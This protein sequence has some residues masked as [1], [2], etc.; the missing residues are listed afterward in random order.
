M[1]NNLDVEVPVYF[2][3]IY[4]NTTS[5]QK[6]KFP[7][8]TPPPNKIQDTRTVFQI[9]QDMLGIL[10]DTPKVNYKFYIDML[11]KR[12]S[13]VPEINSDGIE[14]STEL[15][16]KAIKDFAPQLKEM[17]SNYLK[18]IQDNVIVQ[19]V[20][21]NI[22]PPGS[23]PPGP[24]LFLKSTI[25]SSKCPQHQ[26]ALLT[27]CGATNSCISLSNLSTLGIDV[28]QISTEVKY[29]LTNVTE[30]NN[31]TTILGSIVLNTNIQIKSGQATIAIQYLVLDAPL[32]YTILGSLE[33]E[34]CKAILCIPCKSLDMIL[35]QENKLTW[36]KPTVYISP[37]LEDPSKNNCT[38]TNSKSLMKSLKTRS[39]TDVLK[40][41]INNMEID[42]NS[43]P[44]S[45]GPQHDLPGLHSEPVSEKFLED[46]D[47][48]IQVPS[49]VD[50]NKLDFDLDQDFNH[51]NSD[52]R[53][54]L[55][56][57]SS[58]HP[59]NKNDV[60]HFP[61]YRAVLTPAPDANFVAE[62]PRRHEPWKQEI[63]LE[64][65]AD[66]LNV[67]V[68]EKSESMY[69]CNALLT[70]KAIPF[71]VGSNTKADRH[72]QKTSQSPH[73]DISQ[74][75]FRYTVDQRSHN[76]NLLPAPKIHLPKTSDILRILHGS[77]V[78]LF[79]ISNAFHSV[80][81]SPSSR[82]YTSFW[83]VTGIKYQF[84][85]CCQGMQASPYHFSTPV[86]SI[87]TAVAFKEFCEEYNYTFDSVKDLPSEWIIL[88]V[89]D[90][91]IVVLKH[92]LVKRLHFVLHTLLKHKLKINFSKLK[93]GT[94]SFS[95]LGSEYNLKE[96]VSSIKSDRRNA[97]LAYREPR[98]F[99]EILSR[100]AS[101]NYNSRFL[102]GLQKFLVPL[103]HLLSL[104]RQGVQFH[105]NREHAESWS[106][107]KMLL[108]LDTKLYIPDRTCP[109]LILP[110]ANKIGFC[111]SLYA[112][113]TEE[114]QIGKR[115]T[116]RL[117]NLIDKIFS[118]SQL[119]HH[120]T[121]KE[122]A[123]S[124]VSVK[125]F[126]IP[127]R[128]SIWSIL[129]SD[130]RSLSFARRMKDT[131]S[132]LFQDASF[133]SS[134]SNLSHG[135]IPG[136]YV[137]ISDAVTR[138]FENSQILEDFPVK[139]LKQMP[140][141]KYDKPTIFT[142]EQV[143]QVIWTDLHKGD[144]VD[145]T[146]R[147]TVL[148]NPPI[149]PQT[150]LMQLLQASPQEEF[151]N[152]LL[153]G[154]ISKN[155]TNWT[156]IN[157]K[158]FT[159][160]DF[161]Q[162]LTKCEAPRVLAEINRILK[163]DDL[164]RKTQHFVTNMCLKV[165]VD[166]L[167]HA[168]ITHDPALSLLLD[169]GTA[170]NVDYGPRPANYAACQ[171]YNSGSTQPALTDY[172][173]QYPQMATIDN[174]A[175]DIIHQ[176]EIPTNH[177]FLLGSFSTQELM[178]VSSLLQTHSN[179]FP[180]HL[181]SA[182]QSN[183]FNAII[184]FLLSEISESHREL[185]L[186]YYLPPSSQ[187]R[188]QVNSHPLRIQLISTQEISI[189]GLKHI[190]LPLNLQVLNRS[191]H[192]V[193]SASHKKPD[194]YFSPLYS[195]SVT[196]RHEF[197]TIL[198]FNCTPTAIRI[199][200]DFVFYSL[201]G[202]LNFP[203]ENGH[204]LQ[205]RN[206]ENV[207]C[208]PSHSPLFKVQ[209]A[210]I[211][212]DKEH[213]FVL[214]CHNFMA[215]T[216]QLFH[217]EEATNSKN[218]DP[219][220]RCRYQSLFPVY[221][222]K[223]SLS[224]ETSQNT[225]FNYNDMKINPTKQSF[226]PNGS[227]TLCKSKTCLDFH[228]YPVLIID[229]TIQPIHW[230]NHTKINLDF[231]QDGQDM[232]VDL[233]KQRNK[234]KH[235]APIA[236]PDMFPYQDLGKA[237][238]VWPERD[239]PLPDPP[240][241]DQQQNIDQIFGD[242]QTLQPIPATTKSSIPFVSKDHFN[243][244]LFLSRLLKT[245]DRLTPKDISSLQQVEPYFREIMSTIK[246]EKNF[247][248][249]KNGILFKKITKPTGPTFYVLCLP[250]QFAISILQSFH[251]IA[252]FHVPKN[253][254]LQHYNSRFFTPNIDHLLQQSINSCLKCFLTSNVGVRN[255]KMFKR[256]ITQCSVGEHL[257]LDLIT[258]LPLSNEGFTTLLLIVDV[259]SHYMIGLPLANMQGPAINDA[260]NTIFNI[261]PHPKYLSC[262]HQSSFHTIADFCTRYDI[263]CIKS[264]PS[265]KNELGAID[266]ACRIVTQFLQKVTTSI[267]QTLRLSWPRYIKILFENINAR[268]S[269]RNKFSRTE[270]FYGPL[271]YLPN[272]RVFGS[273]VFDLANDMLSEVKLAQERKLIASEKRSQYT[274][275][276]SISFPRN[277]LVK[278]HLSKSDK[279]TVAGSKKLIPDIQSFFR[280][281]R[282]GPT[283]CQLKNITDGTVRTVKKS[284]L[285]LVTFSENQECLKLIRE[286]FPK[287]LLW[288]FN[289]F[290]RK[291]SLPAY[292]HHMNSKVKHVTFNKQVEVLCLETL[293]KLEC[294]FIERYQRFDLFPQFLQLNKIFPTSYIA[295]KTED[296]DFKN[297]SVYH[298]LFSCPCTSPKEITM[299][300]ND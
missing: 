164:S 151:L 6:F 242:L 294:D 36:S 198:L 231:V 268:Y 85:R 108:Y 293:I 43:T 246:K 106:H 179:L 217:P 16:R 82:Q 72:I 60:G 169:S 189:D 132:A 118:G 299:L 202:W 91:L 111:G 113:L 160:L 69:P 278:F 234:R 12:D 255:F 150:C 107:C 21:L 68:I 261:I 5:I 122:W 46:M 181:Q 286:N 88:Y 180:Q 94:Y 9:F 80:E 227:D 208:L 128:A 143:N 281:L 135:F 131:S 243:S 53:A 221:P 2:Q 156:Q 116:L 152:L 194:M 296:R 203:N 13:S 23:V 102:P 195:T 258:N 285:T 42:F 166:Q 220:M 124:T 248:L 127:I 40:H 76:N 275:L 199:P 65:E 34:N 77:A 90:L 229:N 183:N 71:E 239:L 147:K 17:K 269:N 291:Q 56:S 149:N 96:S 95:F 121:R 105:W 282:S 168:P 204:I 171:L 241:E 210:Q 209:E 295:T 191:T 145:C 252:N 170:L 240:T 48:K 200:P 98:S 87:F 139:S 272:H 75:K 155:H 54:L 100:I 216:F 236:K 289:S 205:I 222:F 63:G 49:S 244:L 35:W 218:Y 141:I 33:L 130:C 161:S 159:Q 187:F 288:E 126:E 66:L 259:A 137:G 119:N 212:E 39:P 86:S 260:L 123:A 215:S 173:N 283:S 196:A 298:L 262:D 228:E 174:C 230:C 74:R 51:L 266:S 64:I 52:I 224:Q 280:V 284:A 59:K 297:I 62:P 79:D 7:L 55:T 211:Y 270:Q 247:E 58:L 144:M 300:I 162:L 114:T 214:T 249:D 274:D 24:L 67:G 232:I 142:P 26:I 190:E 89:D 172:Y 265:S 157:N 276:V 110:D 250:S 245:N 25:P 115:Y 184:K 201:E 92:N 197:E 27:D 47:E 103:L 235:S 292:M 136:S 158:R 185:F 177:K 223:D 45:S 163:L 219:Y 213:T 10:N 153:N 101:L 186:P 4:V 14:L 154:A 237:S 178:K 83:G 207:V 287:S 38:H 133:L 41:S 44:F 148:T 226:G 253:I 138:Q 134:F 256:S 146:I 97:L 99:A 238:D 3:S 277:S 73:I 109:R 81:Y 18:N 140:A 20:S 279:P 263:M 165:R 225:Y 112:I 271:R 290:H 61:G 206:L 188:L 78:C 104:G 233:P 125:K 37:L 32:T 8:K 30:T 182:L 167:N 15:I 251:E 28:N 267:D 257:S 129:L 70:M 117:E 254:M 1:A 264:T 57:Y 22:P 31:N 50:I 193:L 19:N 175:A 93:L 192:L 84:K 120:I 29:S 273:H 11:L 176:E